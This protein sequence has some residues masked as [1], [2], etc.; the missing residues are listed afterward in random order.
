MFSYCWR[1][2][3]YLDVRPWVRFAISSA[4]SASLK[5]RGDEQFSFSPFRFN[6][7]EQAVSLRAG[8]LRMTR[9]LIAV[10]EQFVAGKN[11]VLLDRNATRD[12]LEP[13]RRYFAT[14]FSMSA[15][16]GDGESLRSSPCAMREPAIQRTKHC[17]R[18]WG[19]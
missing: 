3:A 12:S 4:A 7:L 10:V 18:I 2:S 17:E 11:S 9:S 5:V 13:A 19:R 15:S 1:L 8:V 16:S 6:A 14:S